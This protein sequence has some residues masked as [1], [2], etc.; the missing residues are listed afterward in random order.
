MP[1]T[2]K[3]TGLNFLRSIYD[4]IWNKIQLDY[5]ESNVKWEEY[6]G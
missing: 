3:R 5:D 6:T 1:L 2:W 4:V